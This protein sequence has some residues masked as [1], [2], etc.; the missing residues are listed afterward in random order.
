M[1]RIIAIFLLFSVGLSLQAISLDSDAGWRDKVQSYT[2]KA[3]EKTQSYSDQAREKARSYSNKAREKTQSYSNQAREKARSYSNKAHEKT[4]GYSDQVREKARN[5]SNKAREK[6]QSYSNQARETVRDY[7]NRA[8]GTAQDYARVYE[9]KSKQAKKFG[10]NASQRVHDASLRYGSAGKQKLAN[11]Y[12]SMSERS[13]KNI[14]AVRYNLGETGHRLVEDTMVRYG[15]LAGETVA[16]VL[17]RSNKHGQEILTRSRDSMDLVKKRV[18]DPVVRER[19]IAGAVA[20]TAV[21]Y[22]AYEHR[23]EIQYKAIK[24]GMENVRVPVNGE[25]TSVEDLYTV[26]ILQRAPYLKGTK[27]AEDP[28]ALLAYGAVSVGKEDFIEHA[29]IIPSKSGEMRS[30]GGT[31]ES[32]DRASDA[33]SALQ[34]ST[35]WEGMAME[36]AEHGQFGRHGENFAATYQSMESTFEE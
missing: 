30:I 15:R 27:I 8:H 1:K 18:R 23:D 26:Q 24:L 32:S 35:N 28:A 29:P 13:L 12:N 5:Y 9:N 20:A 3:R 19:A 16:A 25:L 10:V 33:I 2:N 4:Q 14:K 36:A 22:Y 6:T 31:I 7:S 34:V 21:G 11:A 17:A